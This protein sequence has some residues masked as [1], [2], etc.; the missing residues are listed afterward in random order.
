[1]TELDLDGPAAPPRSNGEIVFD[2]RWQSRL[3]ATTMA[4][5]ESG[6]IVYDEFRDRLIAEVARQPDQYWASWQDALEGLLVERSLCDPEQLADR[7]RR[8]A[9]HGV[10]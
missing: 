5:C 7:A 9:E 8:F 3:F 1:M 10:D 6:T 4:L 2:E